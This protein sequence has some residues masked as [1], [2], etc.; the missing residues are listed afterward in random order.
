MSNQVEIDD[1][2]GSDVSKHTFY[3]LQRSFSEAQHDTNS[4]HIE[5]VGADL[6]FPVMY[7]PV[8]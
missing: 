6:G 4:F 8:C 7:P 2:T 5:Q 1:N 3:S